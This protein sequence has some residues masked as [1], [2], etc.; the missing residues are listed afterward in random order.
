M[1]T[2]SELAQPTMRKAGPWL[3]VLGIIYPTTVIAFEL[4]T[5]LC[6]TALFDPMP[7]P[8]HIALVS[9]VP[10]TNLWLWFSL[11]T[12]KASGRA[13][14]AG[15]AAAMVALSYSI[16]FLPLYPLSL[17]AILY[18]GL[19]LAPFAPLSA[20]LAGALMTARTASRLPSKSRSTVL[21]LGPILGLALITAL[22][23]PQAATRLALEM[24]KTQ[25]RASEQQALTIMRTIGDRDLLLRLCYDATGRPSGPISA[26]VAGLGGRLFSGGATGVSSTAAARILYY[27]LT[28]DPFNT[29]PPPFD[30]GVWSFAREFDFD[31]DQG[32]SIV[33]Q[34]VRGVSLAVSRIDGSI[35]ADDGVGYLEWTLEFR[36][37]GNRDSEARASIVLPPGGFVS[38][39]SLWVAGEEREAVFASRARAQ[40][41]YQ[42]I[43]RIEQRD[44]LLVTTSGADRI[45][46]QAFP[47]PAGGTLRLRIGI[48]AP[49]D[50]AERGQAA[51][52]LPAVVDR[53]FSI[54]PELQHEVWFEGDG[55]AVHAPPGT[56]IQAPS[57]GVFRLRG[58]FTDAALTATRPRITAQRAP[59]P[60]IS[61]TPVRPPSGEPSHTASVDS[62]PYIVQRVEERRISTRSQVVFILDG[63]ARA[64]GGAEAI[65]AA[66]ALLADGQS[67]GLIIAEDNPVRI[68]PAPLDADH[69][70]RIAEALSRVRFHGGQDN[71]G[72][73]ADAVEAAEPHEG[74]TVVWVHGPQP[75]AFWRD[76]ARLEQTL[77]RS[78]RL[79]QLVLYPIASG[80]N[81]LLGDHPWFWRARTLAWSGDPVADLTRLAT[82]LRDR[83]HWAAETAQA[84]TPPANARRGSDHTARLWAYQRS[85]DLAS[86][87]RPADR[88]AAVALAHTYQLV[89]PVSGA[90]VLET[91]ADYERAG[92]EPPTAAE[93]P[94]VPEPEI[95][96]LLFVACFMFCWFAWRRNR[97]AV[98]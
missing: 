14:I 6:A 38:R 23:A 39:A 42:R 85:I 60:A 45:L 73:L 34:R 81:Q 46:L 27:R 21:W 49:L 84:D 8:A 75:V 67:V 59:V 37:G 80:P 50:L 7:T 43:V 32:G 4:A 20:L 76:T 93:V 3:L 16:I 78:T 17:V 53:N 77:A 56:Q 66:L 5:R 68:D 11:R 94:T 64:R 30:T 69:R 82:M 55:A 29:T 89:T 31:E 33:G 12:D 61:Y 58:A 28:G 36:N 24:A 51:L 44:P 91:D 15:G 92:L 87:S 71:T 88:D 19:G 48:T 10:A 25:E 70:R 62:R 65:S 97:M 35:N 63:S 1:T 54:G 41:A 13:V 18:F 90:V 9:A 2:T 72:A 95:Y 22:D 86:S 74:A 47:I 98:A 52:A 57:P 26:L 83:V 79:P 40:E 96:L